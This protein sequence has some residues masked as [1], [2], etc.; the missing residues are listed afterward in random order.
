[1]QKQET[2]FIQIILLYINHHR[3]GEQKSTV[4]IF[5][6]E[7][8][9]IEH[10]WTDQHAYQRN[11]NIQY[12]LLAILMGQS[13][14]DLHT[15][16]WSV[17]LLLLYPLQKMLLELQSS[18]LRV[19][20]ATELSPLM[21]LFINHVDVASISSFTYTLEGQFLY[22]EPIKPLW[23]TREPML[24]EWMNAESCWIFEYESSQV[25]YGLFSWHNNI[26]Y[27]SVYAESE[28]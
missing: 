11:T 7:T 23:L 3:S 6:L 22:E 27:A 1:M 17:N 9:S 15:Y 28:F 10:Q 25:L 12:T 2:P 4:M 21:I 18:T 13:S 19:R 20:E 8:M 5:S 24:N 26:F 16:L 14:Q